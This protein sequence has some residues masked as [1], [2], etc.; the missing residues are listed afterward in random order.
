M[1]FRLRH[2]K[3]AY[4][5]VQESKEAIKAEKTMLG[6]VRGIERVPPMVGSL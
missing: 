6:T 5:A 3:E 2:P 1:V 4:R